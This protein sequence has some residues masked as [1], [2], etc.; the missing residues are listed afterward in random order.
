VHLGS[1]VRVPLGRQ[2]LPGYVVG[3]TDLRPPFK[4]RAV[5]DLL[6]DG[7]VFGPAELALA[8]RVAETYFCPLAHALRLI[9]PPGAARRPA[10]S[11]VLTEAGQALV[12]SGSLPRAAQQQAVLR[13]LEAAGGELERE[14]LEPLTENKS[15]LSAVLRALEDK[16]L[17]RVLRT[18]ARPGVSARAQRWA[19]LA[20]EPEQALAEAERR[21]AAA[22]RQAEV[23]RE[24][25]ATPALPLTALARGS[26]LAL[27]E[28]GLVEVYD[29]QQRRRP[30]DQSLGQAETRPEPT[31]DQVAV[32][33][34]IEQALD[35]GAYWGGLLHGVT[36]SG[37]TEVYLRAL[38]MTLARGRSA[39]VLIPE[40]S[41]TPQTVG[42]FAARFGEGIA[43]LHSSLS[44]GERYDE[45]QRV[46]TGEAR[47]VIGARSALFAPCHR[48]GL[49]VVDEEHE[50]SYKQD[51]SPRYHAVTVA[52]W[53]A[54]QEHAVLLLGTATPA[55][56]RYWAACNP[57]DSSLELLE[58]PNRIGGVPMPQVTMIDLRGQQVLG[59]EATFAEE[60]R[61]ALIRSLERGEQVMIFLNRRGFST[62]VICRDCGF[63][64]R[65]PH[66]AVSLIY[67]RDSR[68]M[69]CHHCD[70][71]TGVPDQCENCQ[72]YDIG[73]HGLGTE[74]LA[75]QI[76]RQFPEYRAVRLDRDTIGGKGAYARILGEFAR[77]EAQILIGTQMIAKGHDFPEVTMVGVINADVGLYRP[78]FRAA[79]RTFQLLTQVSGRAGRANKPG[80]VFVQTYNP[81]H[82]A[83][84]SAAGHDFDA[85][86]RVEIAAR[87]EACYPP[88]TKLANLVI[89]HPDQQTALDSARRIA[90]LLQE[91]GLRHGSG[92][93]QF[94]GPGACPLHKLRGR[95]R[96][97]ILLKGPDYPA[98]AEAARGLLE[99][100]DPPAELRVTVDMDPSDMM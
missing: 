13:A 64:L 46:A 100:L 37:K 63:V 72:G 83:L 23:L 28:R 25:A 70:H 91:L 97:Q 16:G 8:R 60:T 93:L 92:A 69:R 62:F 7:P 14:K 52:Q 54:E 65:C 67:H 81:E 59:P 26:V 27:E 95:F 4:L 45:W 31:A 80:E 88:F 9:L 51:S 3:L 57:E 58:L 20:V 21:Q 56:E 50:P 10:Q 2:H 29:Q 24:L 90:V 55:L 22:P 84:S 75:D 43:I 87:E 6:L 89:S 15:R 17:V 85:F 41:L 5:E 32:L 11:V 99:R 19:R 94:I 47:V 40:I 30:E 61:D 66:C 39:I 38:E 77:G 96:Y 33:K 86:Y 34:R 68:T 42:R 36:G 73:F 82:Y 74:R 79:E 49:I 12:A 48:L 18:L 76:S 35:G 44:P 78:D 71:T 1:Y 53:R 98:L